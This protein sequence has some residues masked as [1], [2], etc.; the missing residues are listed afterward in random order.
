MHKT[1]SVIFSHC[2]YSSVINRFAAARKA[3]A[4]AARRTF[5]QQCVQTSCTV[6]QSC[7][8]HI[9]GWIIWRS[10]LMCRRCSTYTAAVFRGAQGRASPRRCSSRGE[11][12]LI[13]KCFQCKLKT[14]FMF[15]CD[16]KCDKRLVFSCQ[17]VNPHVFLRRAAESRCCSDQ[18]HTPLMLL[19][20]IPIPFT[21]F[22]FFNPH[23]KRPWEFVHRC[24]SSFSY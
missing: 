18:I 3:A 9:S 12:T 24:L 15:N 7:K 23:F 10:P 19:T 13:Q 14:T 20:P 1:V 6:G 5:I 17:G 11:E 2:V 8:L 21:C 4:F 16:M 22:F